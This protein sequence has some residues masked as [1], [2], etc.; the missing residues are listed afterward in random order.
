M[1]A[2]PAQGGTQILGAMPADRYAQCLTVQGTVKTSQVQFS[3]E[4]GRARRCATTGAGD[5]PDSTEKTA[6][7]PQLQ[8]VVVVVDTPVV[9]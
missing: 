7:V 3:C 8:F 2:P 1:P 9:A 5:G 6:M 4:V